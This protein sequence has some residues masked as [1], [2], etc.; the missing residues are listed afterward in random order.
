ME[1]DPRVAAFVL[2]GGEGTRLRPLTAQMPK[3]ALP[4]AG[5]CRIVDFVLSN[6][7]NA[8]VAPIL[9]LLHYRPQPLLE[10][11]ATAWRGCGVQ[12][13]VAARGYAGTADAVGQSL[14]WLE[15]RA[16]DLVGVFA[17]DH[18]YRFDVRQMAAFHRAA[19]ADVTIATLPV[20]VAEATAF[21]VLRLAE[22]GTRIIAFDEKPVRPAALPGDPAHACISMGNY[23]FR[24]AVLRE[25]LR[26]AAARGEHDFGHHVL[27]RL[28]AERRVHAYD[29]RAN[30]VP[31][32]R[33]FEEAA[34]WRDV[35]TLP[36]YLASQQDLQAAEAPLVFDNPCWPI[37]R[38]LHA[39][40]ADGPPAAA[41]PVGLAPLRCEASPEA[42]R[43]AGP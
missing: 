27:P 9:V 30:R 39:R 41:A 37:R 13:V 7:V 31:G 38:T 36:T 10:H 43:P 2:A 28:V 18:V 17:A 22:G 34:Y 15:G 11:L 12:P 20:P 25:A 33:P 1:S 5:R 32:L 35:G 42:A 26:A 23:L 19:Q 6:L 14:E 40:A 8:G 16:I 4:M 24:P 29:F 3:P 21:G